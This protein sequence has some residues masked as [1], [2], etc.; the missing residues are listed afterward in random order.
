[1]RQHLPNAISFAR[2]LAAPYICWLIS[3]GHYSA[4]IVWF[5][6]AG[7]TDFLDG[8]LARQLKVSSAFGALLD[9]VADKV[10][11][12][13]A[14]L[15]LA[16]GGLIPAWMAIVIFGRDLLI[17]LIAGF[18]MIRGIRRDFPPSLWGKWSTLAQILYV[19]GVVATRRGY[20]VPLLD[21]LLW[22]TAALTSISG[23]HYLLRACNAWSQ[24]T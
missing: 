11:Q 4:A 5:A 12:S 24:R 15:V 22:I 6:L 20:P 16:Y 18:L 17:L 13:G 1:M 10:L 19:L 21:P 3:E 2:L 8:W 23:V 14:V 7:F 9:P